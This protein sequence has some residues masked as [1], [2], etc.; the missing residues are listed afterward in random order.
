MRPI[1]E[2]LISECRAADPTRLVSFASN[3]YERDICTD[4][5]DV[6]AMN[7]YPGWT[8]IDKSHINDVDQVRPYFEN[9]SNAMPQDK[10]LMIS[11]TGGGGQLGF[12]DPFKARCSEEYQSELLEEICDMLLND[13]R[14]CGLCIWQFCNAKSYLSSTTRI[15]GYNDKGLLDEYRRPKMAWDTVTRCIAESTLYNNNKC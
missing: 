15:N 2:K 12:R 1:I 3:K 8:H 5:V 4:L 10:P 13:H 9:L 7:P 6:V 11:E 14:Y